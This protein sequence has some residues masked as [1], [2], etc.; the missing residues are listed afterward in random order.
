[1][2]A[3]TCAVA[4]VARTSMHGALRSGFARHAWGGGG[5]GV[6]TPD[7]PAQPVRLTHT[8]TPLSLRVAHPPPLVATPSVCLRICLVLQEE[9]LDSGCE[10]VFAC[11]EASGVAGQVVPHGTEHWPPVLQAA[12]GR[13][14]AG[15]RAGVTPH[16]A[17]D[18]EGSTYFLY[19]VDRKPVGCFKPQD[20][21]PF[22]PCN[23]KGWLGS[24]GQMSFRRGILSGEGCLRE[25]AA[26]LLDHG[27]LARVP[28]TAMVTAWHAAFCNGA[29][30]LSPSGSGSGGAIGSSS[31]TGTARPGRS[32][33]GGSAGG[34]SAPTSPTLS[35]SPA[36]SPQSRLKHK[37]GS[38]Q[39]FVEFDSTSEDWAPSKFSVDVGVAC[40]VSAC[41][42][43]GTN[44]GV[45]VG[46]FE[47]VRAFVL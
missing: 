11:V 23:R 31:S 26:Y 9:K 15:F 41:M 4:V 37:V 42:G 43:R 16:L 5:S 38:F 45:G 6:P 2:C 18:G 40:V 35:S 1:M 8:H 24:F 12:V 28:A 20:E 14:E 47:R 22:T 30:D 21:E 25:A 7:T 3:R 32:S 34:G 33:S 36:P 27:G 44:L 46:W 17:E 19:D 13:A 39:E 10:L 29:G